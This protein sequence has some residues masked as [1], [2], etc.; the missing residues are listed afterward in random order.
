MALKYDADL[1]VCTEQPC[2]CKRFTPND[3]EAYRIMKRSPD[4]EDFIPPAKK[5]NP[6][7]KLN[8]SSY[9]LSFFTTLE[10]AQAQ[11]AHLEGKGVEVSK[12]M[13][14]SIGQIRITKSDGLTNK[15]NGRGHFDLHEN[16]STEFNNRQI[17]IHHSKSGCEQ[18]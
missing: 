12:V 16:A 17:T 9:A 4:S 1:K 18:C 13:G 8:C 15:P 3:V 2:P 10:K 7:Q 11:V 5:K 14:D 6:P